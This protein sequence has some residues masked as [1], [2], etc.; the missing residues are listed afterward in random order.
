M[1][2]ILYWSM[3]QILVGAW[4]FISPFVFG[5]SPMT[6][7]RINNMFFGAV[8]F[9]LGLGFWIYERS[10]VCYQSPA[11]SEYYEHVGKKAA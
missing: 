6:G 4:L 11:K 8:V 10:H 1:R 5:F 2:S 9:A 3:F 7:A